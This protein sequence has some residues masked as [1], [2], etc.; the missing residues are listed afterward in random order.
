MRRKEQRAGGILYSSQERDEKQLH[1][2]GGWANTDVLTDMQP[3]TET[4]EGVPGVCVP[5]LARQTET[6]WERERERAETAEKG[7]RQIAGQPPSRRSCRAASLRR[8][9]GLLSACY[10]VVFLH[11]M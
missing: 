1:R 7:G 4:L 5:P 9:V 8:S 6:L 10:C 2:D 3:M 11:M